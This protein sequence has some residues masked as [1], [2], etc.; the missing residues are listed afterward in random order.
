[1]TPRLPLLCLFA[2]SLCAQTNIPLSPLG[3]PTPTQ[4]VFSYTAPDGN[5]C[6]IQEGT[7][8][9]FATVDHDVDA[10]LFSGSN[11]DT[12]TG[13]LAQGRHRVIILGFRG[14]ATASNGLIYSRA[15]QAATTHYLKVSCDSGS[16]IGTATFTTPNPPMGNTAPDYIPFNYSGFGNYGW[17]SINYTAIT[18]GNI[19]TSCPA[20]PTCV[21]DPLTGFQL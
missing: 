12:R 16:Y 11:L 7:D 8:P 2:L 3:M 20:S 1:M 18:H 5:A 15:L 14:T 17:P 19:S 9:T 10:T 4:A 6:T 13:N 21:V